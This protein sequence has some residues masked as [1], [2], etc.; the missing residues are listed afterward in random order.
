MQIF[1]SFPRLLVVPFLVELFQP[2]FLLL[3]LLLFFLFPRVYKKNS[4]KV[5]MYDNH[6]QTVNRFSRV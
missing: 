4:K 6:I 5:P 1:W 2:T 3:L